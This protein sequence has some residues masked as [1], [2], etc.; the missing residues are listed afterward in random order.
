MEA[1][2]VQI[3]KTVQIQTAA[4]SLALGPKPK[5]TAKE[6][7]ERSVSLSRD[8]YDVDLRSKLN[9]FLRNQ[10]ETEWIIVCWSFKFEVS[11]LLDLH[12]SSRNPMD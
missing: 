10:I 3:L 2:P 6:K 11:C 12:R 8:G 7:K 1:L 4:T 9:F 5:L